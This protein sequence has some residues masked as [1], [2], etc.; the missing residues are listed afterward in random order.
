MPRLEIQDFPG[1]DDEE[2][3]SNC[4]AAFTVRQK[5]RLAHLKDPKVPLL[6]PLH[7]MLTKAEFVEWAYSNHPENITLMNEITQLLRHRALFPSPEV[8]LTDAFARF[9][10]HFNE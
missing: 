6:T 1:A 5:E 4:F 10:L 3:K 2:K 9:H 7:I 8:P